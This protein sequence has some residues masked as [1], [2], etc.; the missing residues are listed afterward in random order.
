MHRQAPPDDRSD[1]PDHVAVIIPAY[2]AAATIDETLWSVRVQTC[3]SLDIVVVDDGS[4]DAT[5]AI[6]AAH[7]ACDPRVRLLSQINGGV[8]AA[9]NLGI[10]RSTAP[11]IAFIDA[12]DLWTRDK[13]EKQLQALRQAPAN[14]GLVYCWS[15]LIDEQGRITSLDHR[16]LY[17]GPV[18]ERLCEVNLIANGSSPLIPRAIIQEVGGFDPGLRAKRAQGCE[19]LDLYLRIAEHY[20]FAVVPEHLTGYRQLGS[21]M[22]SDLMQ[23][24][25]SWTL[26]S[27]AAGRRRP[28]SRAALERG[29]TNCTA[30]LLVRAIQY[31][32][33]GDSFRLATRLLLRD[34]FRLGAIGWQAATAALR[35]LSGKPTRS[36]ERLGP[37]AGRPFIP[38]RDRPPLPP[39]AA[40]SARS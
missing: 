13:I 34:P 19:D 27:A 40:S 15:A 18:L 4:N 32:R 22:S 9:R 11:L 38:P 2:N 33:I 17:D 21:A 30:W 31:R 7:A 1:T 35:R 20:A 5:P 36:R 12:D 3:R 25:R 8:A 29:V 10:E 14:T 26:V 6:V 39:V 16:P 23:M 24:L 37:L 28:A